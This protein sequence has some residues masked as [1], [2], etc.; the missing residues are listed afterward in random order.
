MKI[1]IISDTH[2]NLTAIDEAAKIFKKVGAGLIIHAGDWNA[3]FSL[4]RLAMAK[5]RIVGIFGNVDGEREYLKTKAKDTGA[6]LL[7]EF[8]EL[9]I[10]G[11]KM[12][13]IHGKDERIVDALAKSGQYSA[14]IRGHTHK[15]E[16]RELGST[17]VINPGEACGY[18]TDKRTVAI[19][20]T[21]NL[22]VEVIEF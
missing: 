6:E 11:T 18:L 19:L 17:L 2:D 8:G 3:P 16:V 9:E 15:Q 20:D 7:G 5:I 14:V 1:G 13:I 10:E 22:E 4:V 12:A 21:L